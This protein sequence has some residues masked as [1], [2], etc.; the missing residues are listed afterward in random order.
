MRNRKDNIYIVK[1][2]PTRNKQDSYQFK[3][4]LCYETQNFRISITKFYKCTTNVYC[5]L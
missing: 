2:D 1:Q 3:Y 4:E 5:R